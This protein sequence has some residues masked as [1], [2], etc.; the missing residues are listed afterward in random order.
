ME[1]VRSLVEQLS[2]EE[3][4]VLR[5]RY[6]EER[7]AREIADELGLGSQ[8]RVYTILDRAVRK[9]RKLLGGND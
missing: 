7:T 4:E 6:S 3:Q 8:R 2:E 1:E 5:L 9:L